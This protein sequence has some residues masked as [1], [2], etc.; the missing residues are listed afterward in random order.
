LRDDVQTAVAEL[1]TLF[2]DKLEYLNKL[3]LNESDKLHYIK[4]D[5]LEKIFEIIEDDGRIIEDIDVV[6]YRISGIE[7][8]LSKILGTERRDMYSLLCL[9]KNETGEIVSLRNTI[10]KTLEIIHSKRKLLLEKMTKASLQLKIRIDELS[11][12]DALKYHEPW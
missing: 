9:E 4:S 2:R 1:T 10:R 11:R 6:D 5:N 3:L 7:D 8:A 12:I